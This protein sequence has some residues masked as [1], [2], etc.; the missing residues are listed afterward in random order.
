MQATDSQTQLD[1]ARDYF[2]ALAEWSTAG[3]D[4]VLDSVA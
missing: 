4:T 1:R 3:R 2:D